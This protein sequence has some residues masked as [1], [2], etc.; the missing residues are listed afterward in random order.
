M[1]E[2]GLAYLVTS[3]RSVH[4]LFAHFE[5]KQFAVLMQVI[6]KCRHANSKRNTIL[7][8]AECKVLLCYIA[9]KSLED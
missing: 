1:E 2:W 5:L 7:K 4:L 8:D 9:W 3:G 6:T